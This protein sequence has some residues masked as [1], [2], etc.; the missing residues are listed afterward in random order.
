MEEQFSIEP[1]IDD[2]SEYSAMLA[3][4]RE[5][6]TLNAT[7]LERMGFDLPVP[8]AE[9]KKEAMQIYHANPSA[10]DKPSTLGTAIVLEKM[11]AKHDYVVLLCGF[12]MWFS[13]N[14]K[15]FV[16][17]RDIGRGRLC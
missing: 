4:A 2:P 14:Y 1:A 17:I 3:C 11:L 5:C 13:K 9:E 16:R 6:F 15:M 12:I 8:T 7:F 10:P